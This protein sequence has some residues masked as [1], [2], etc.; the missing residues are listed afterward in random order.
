MNVCST[1]TE[2][3]LSLNARKKLND[4]RVARDTNNAISMDTVNA[5]GPNAHPRGIHIVIH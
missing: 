5:T 3:M 1:L 2:D 4:G